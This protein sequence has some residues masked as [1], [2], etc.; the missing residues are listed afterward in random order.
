MPQPRDD[1]G[2]DSGEPTTDDN[3]AAAD[4]VPPQPPP[5]PGE[6][7]NS[8]ASSSLPPLDLDQLEP[9]LRA[10]LAYRPPP[11]GI[12][13]PRLVELVTAFHGKA[14]DSSGG[15]TQWL[16][17]ATAL[18]TR[19]VRKHVLQSALS[20]VNPSQPA[21]QPAPAPAPV[22]V[23]ANV[24]LCAVLTCWFCVIA[25]PDGG[26]D[27]MACGILPHCARAV[28]PLLGFYEPPDAVIAAARICSIVGRLAQ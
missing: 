17:R 27:V 4:S 3:A 21:N 18:G 12:D 13:A 1:D 26:A 2:N 20:W 28:D 9:E 22:A 23:P 10:L 14:E 5:R 6:I 25:K 19:M 11:S 24:A 8:S 15:A 7:G 16:S